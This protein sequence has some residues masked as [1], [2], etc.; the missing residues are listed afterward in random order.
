M[1]GGDVSKPDDIP[2]DVWDAA[3][4]SVTAAPVYTG[5]LHENVARAIMAERERCADLLDEESYAMRDQRDE[6]I[7]HGTLGGRRLPGTVKE[8]ALIERRALF[9]G[10]ATMAAAIRKGTP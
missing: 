2:Q 6:M 1:G 8:L 10:Y 3:S 4:Y 9:E 7:E 5:A